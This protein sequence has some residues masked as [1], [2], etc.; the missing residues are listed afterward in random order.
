MPINY[1]S[2]FQ[3]QSYNDAWD[4][5]TLSL[6]GGFPVWDHVILTASNESQARAYQAQIDYRL[7][8]AK[9]PS[10]TRYAVI[11][12]RDNKRVGSGGATLGV[13][14][15]VFEQEHKLDGI[16]ILVIHSGGD[17]KRVPQ[18][19]A[20][21][22]LFS[23]VP[24]ILP[25]GRRS[26]LFDEF[27]IGMSGVATRLSEGML[28]C[29]GDV[30]LLFNPLQIDF[31]G[32]GAAALSMKESVETGKDHG[33]YLKGVTNNVA[34][35]LHKQTIETLDAL[36]AVDERGNVDI[37]TGAVI[38][39]ANILGSL[40]A[41]INT[42][43]KYNAL[44]ND[45]ARL[46]FYADFLYPLAEDSTLEAFYKE[47]PEGDFTD[48]LRAGRGLLW[49][50]LHQYS[51][52]LI[53]L[54]PASFIHFGTSGELRRL[55][56]E[57]VDGYSFL[58]WSKRVNCNRECIGYAANNS[59]ISLRAEIRKGA[60]IEDSYIHHGTVIGEN[61]IISGVTLD[62]QNI[63]ANTVLHGLKLRDGRFVVR[64]Y[65]VG[66][67]PKEKALFGK[68]LPTTLWE[69][70]IYPVGDTIKEAV[71]ATLQAYQAYAEEFPTNGI[72]L[73]E[74]FHQADTSAILEWQ[75]RLDEKIKVESL[76]EAIDNRKPLDEALSIFNG[77]MTPRAEKM[78]L[79]EIAKLTDSDL[80]Q[81]GRKIRIYYVLS[82]LTGKEGY[83][84]SCFGTIRDTILRDAVAGLSY[85]Q[86]NQI[87]EAEVVERLPVR[88]NWGGGWSD[89]P[90]YCMEHG[91]TVL[92]AAITLD[93]QLPVEVCVRRVEKGKFILTSGDN[94]SYQEFTDIA[95]L[96]D[97]SNPYDPFALHKAAL[98]ACGVI[99]YQKKISIGDIT[100]RLGG[101]VYLSTQVT[102]IPRGS[103][104]GTSSILAGAC[105]KAVMKFL[106]QMLSE[107]ELYNRVLCM[108]QIMS[109]GGGWQDQVGGLA[110]GIKM[111]TSEPGMHQEITCTPMRI[112]KAS[113]EEL[114]SRLCL[115]YTG[116][117]R[118][119][120]NLLREVVGKYISS[121]PDAV[122]VL[123]EIQRIAVLMRFELEKGNI[124]GFAQLLNDHWELS[125]RLDAGSTNTCINQLFLTVDDLID[126]KMICGAGG[127]GFLQVVLKK[128]MTFE[129]LN[130]R[131]HE[132]FQDS[133]AC[134]WKC[135][136]V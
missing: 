120:R 105:V 112:S 49:N 89:T 95:A 97:G 100:E 34:R 99:P 25:D 59:Y 78:L 72:S 55:M 56:A 48:E 73:K 93:G 123:Y 35:F 11:P 71:D 16:K 119:A 109:T 15:Y 83:A 101:G 4:A 65:G 50:A 67:N 33:V 102:G 115:I 82:R 53:R 125:K 63:P 64:M 86:D 80:S 32:K 61:C 81:F 42:D 110:P 76:L 31:Y 94:D 28:V 126:G 45:R 52:K 84:S 117:R 98:I 43:A 88:V 24:R 129:I 121:Q 85:S 29:S 135:A 90:P 12:D 47:K 7:S 6:S 54:S 107:N 70:P 19:S 68:H 38:L 113:L 111:V 40:Y 114:N 66:D 75:K 5:Y 60:Y 74:S 116:Q 118:L 133:G 39:D 27:I 103:G 87:A 62:G 37:D 57:D 124:D 10:K 136:I 36:G 26:T 14:K 44:V 3:Q 79:Y 1:N 108:E 69:A 58:G 131:L 46:S 2:L 128:G 134:A 22:K 104:L 21:G 17:S 91:G 51:M 92:N 9:L 13:I 18:Y 127:G 8:L 106:G 77:A 20:C 30:L 130:E 132:V 23:P 96:Q 122:D 41:L